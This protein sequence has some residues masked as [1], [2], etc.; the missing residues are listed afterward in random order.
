MASRWH[1]NARL[2]QIETVYFETEFLRFLDR[3]SRQHLV[4]LFVTRSSLSL[5]CGLTMS[6]LT[7]AMSLLKPD[8]VCVAQLLVIEESQRGPAAAAS[9]GLLLPKARCRLQLDGYEGTLHKDV[10]ARDQIMR[11]E[12]TR[13]RNDGFVGAMCQ[14]GQA[15][16]SRHWEERATSLTETNT[17]RMNVDNCNLN[18]VIKHRCQHFTRNILGIAIHVNHRRIWVYGFDSRYR[19]HRK[20]SY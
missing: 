6:P 10:P 17:K 16:P 7:L 2:R 8:H 13:W 1:A 9:R 4:L 5:L 15:G 20:R 11:P 14:A 3:Q 18:P 19:C 12:Q